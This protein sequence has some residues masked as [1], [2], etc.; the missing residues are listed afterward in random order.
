MDPVEKSL[1]NY[2]CELTLPYVE[3][4]MFTPSVV[5]CG[6]VY[7]ARLFCHKRDEGTMVTTESGETAPCPSMWSPEMRHFSGYDAEE[8]A[9]VAAMLRATHMQAAECPL[10]TSLVRKFGTATWCRVALMEPLPAA[11]MPPVT[12]RAIMEGGR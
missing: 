5:A 1:S 7:L 11:L 2:L 6:A 4:T 9:H 3:Y 8:L 12:A 10:A